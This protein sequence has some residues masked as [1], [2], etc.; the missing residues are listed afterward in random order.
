MEILEQNAAYVVCVKPAGIPLK[1]PEKTAVMKVRPTA[2]PHLP[3][4]LLLAAAFKA[5]RSIVT[6][7]FSIINTPEFAS[8]PQA[9][10]LSCHNYIIARLSLSVKMNEK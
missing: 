7:A 1:I 4:S 10:L 8:C 6:F 2:Q 5:G 3:F 9:V